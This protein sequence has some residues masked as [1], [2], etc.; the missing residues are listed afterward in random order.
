MLIP[1]FALGRAQEVLL[2]L[3]EAQ[4][5]G[6]I[7]AFPIYADGLVRTVCNVYQTFP[8]ALTPAL[9]RRMAR[10]EDVFLGGTVQAVQGAGQR[11]AI[12]RGEG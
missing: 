3:R 4:E 10:N 8:E 1:A 6:D 5:H 12:L 11:E 7:P 9:Q 2:V